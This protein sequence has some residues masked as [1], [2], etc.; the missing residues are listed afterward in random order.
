MSSATPRYR[1]TRVFNSVSILAGLDGFREQRSG[2]HRRAVAGLR[3]PLRPGLR[4][5]VRE[6]SV[7]P[8]LPTRDLP[9]PDLV[10]RQRPAPQPVWLKIVPPTVAE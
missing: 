4:L 3:M 8:T 9:D 7:L 10:D 6:R 1:K 5:D 2:P